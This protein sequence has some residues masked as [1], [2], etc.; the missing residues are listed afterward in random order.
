MTRRTVWIL[1]WV[2]VAFLVL[3]VLLWL[4]NAP[5]SSSGVTGTVTLLI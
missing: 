1:G 5:T 2:I 4:W 3:S